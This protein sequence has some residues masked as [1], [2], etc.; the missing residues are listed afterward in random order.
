MKYK[1]IT[2]LAICGLLLSSNIVRSQDDLCED[3][4]NPRPERRNRDVSRQLFDFNNLHTYNT[5][6]DHIILSYEGRNRYLR[7][8]EDEGKFQDSCIEEIFDTFGTDLDRDLVLELLE[9][10]DDR[11]QTLSVDEVYPGYGI[12]R[13]IA[14]QLGYLY[15]IDRND[16]QVCS[17]AENYRDRDRDRD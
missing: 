15:E 1:A 11:A 2:L 6:L 13:R 8:L 16:E 17:L 5:C 14:L 7:V 9:V 10:A 12:R 3:Y 4:V